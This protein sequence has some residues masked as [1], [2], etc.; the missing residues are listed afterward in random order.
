VTQISEPGLF[1]PKPSRLES[2][3][4]TTTRVALEIINGEAAAK[5]AK[6]ECLRAARLAREAIAAAIVAMPRK[7]H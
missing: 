5:T 3:S 4:D 7:K 1:K 6:T 2:R